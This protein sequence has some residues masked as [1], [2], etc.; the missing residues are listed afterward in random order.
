MSATAPAQW[1][2]ALLQ[3]TDSFYPTGSYAHSFGLEGLHQEGVVTDVETLRT[4]LLDYVLPPLARTDLPI[5]AHTWEAAADPVDWTKIQHLCLLTTALRGTKEPRG[6]C[7]AIGS[8]RVDLASRL[9]GGIAEEFNRRAKA[10]D[11]PRPSSVAAAI[12][13]RAINVPKEAVL[14]GIVYASSAAFVS[15]SVKLLRLGQNTVHSIL[16]DA[17]ANSE[18]LIEQALSVKLED[19][20]TFNPWWDIASAHHEH[21]DYRLFIS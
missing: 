17:L 14:A 19:L 8:Q 10:G 16:A 15:A 5:A 9:H 12:E 7:E 1:V 2:A 21:A 3:T 18:V 20:G 11:W 13:G 4:F 6:A